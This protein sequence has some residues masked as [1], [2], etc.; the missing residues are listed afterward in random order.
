MRLGRDNFVATLELIDVERRPQVLY[1]L[2]DVRVQTFEDGILVV[3]YRI[4]AEGRPVRECRQAW[5]CAP[6]RRAGEGAI[7]S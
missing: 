6:A 2:F 3:G 1:P 4:Q 5:Y 7:T